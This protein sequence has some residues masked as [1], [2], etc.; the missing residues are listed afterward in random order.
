MLSFDL[1]MIILVL[2]IIPIHKEN[3][4]QYQSSEERLLFF[5]ISAARS[6]NGFR[7][8]DAGRCSNRQDTTY[9]H[10]RLEDV[11]NLGI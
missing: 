8:I 6:G 10:W 9:E 3:Q 2:I 1:P 5:G 4:L 7:T 11:V